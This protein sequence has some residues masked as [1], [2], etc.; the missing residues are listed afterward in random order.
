MHYLI[1]FFESL[2]FDKIVSNLEFSTENEQ[3]TVTKGNEGYLFYFSKVPSIFRSNLCQEIMRVRED[4]AHLKLALNNELAEYLELKSQNKSVE[5]FIQAK[6]IGCPQEFL[7]QFEENLTTY[8]SFNYI[9]LTL[10]IKSKHPAKTKI[11]QKSKI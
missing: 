7:S 8:S 5:K 2:T 9:Y 1:D 11:I 4:T 10:K 3:L 6:E